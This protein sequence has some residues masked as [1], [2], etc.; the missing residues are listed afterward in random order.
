MSAH[1]VFF[2]QSRKEGNVCS[3]IIID[4]PVS[5]LFNDRAKPIQ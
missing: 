5:W 2:V 1:D 4:A 3:Q